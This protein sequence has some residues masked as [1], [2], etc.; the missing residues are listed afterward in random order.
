MT[1]DEEIK[2]YLTSSNPEFRS[3]VEQHNSLKT[4]LHQL[5]EQAHV[6]DQE[7][8]ESITLKKKKLNLKD[9][10]NRMIQE[11]RHKQAEPKHP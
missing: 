3:L 5:T 4:K 11:Y 6:T 9:E 10:M 8:L 2:D 1:Q 7:Q